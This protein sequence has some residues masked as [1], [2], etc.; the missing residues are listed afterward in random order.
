MEKLPIIVTSQYWIYPEL[1]FCA[2]MYYSC[3]VWASIRL[4]V[5]NDILSLEGKACEQIATHSAAQQQTY[6][7]VQ[8]PFAWE[9]T[10]R[11][12]CVCNYT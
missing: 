10:H 6:L 9:N 7:N 1:Q 8:V 11:Q 5:T 3:S 2:V 12:I 4:I